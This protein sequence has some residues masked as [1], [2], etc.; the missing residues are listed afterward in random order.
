MSLETGSATQPMT[1]QE[2]LSPAASSGGR[3]AV[4][5]SSGSDAMA[6]ANHTPKSS[7]EVA[8]NIEVTDSGIIRS[9]ASA[10]SD[11]ELAL[12]IQMSLE[13]GPATQPI[14]KQEKLSPAASSGGRPAVATSSGSGA[15]A[16]ANH[17]P[18]SSEEVAG[19]IEVT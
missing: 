3:P 4:A 19:N 14:T 18:E 7:E 5:T 11:D 1:K 2:K 6:S 16:S 9:S 10:G 13:T 8:G 17:T 15:M 12:A